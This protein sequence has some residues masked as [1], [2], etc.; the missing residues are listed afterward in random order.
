MGEHL[1]EVGQMFIF[2]LAGNQNFIQVGIAAGEATMNLW[3]AWAAFL[4]QKG[5]R[6]NWNNP[7]GVTTAVLGMV[8]LPTRR[9]VLQVGN[10]VL[11]QNGDVV[12]DSIVS[13]GLPARRD[14]PRDHVQRRDPAARRWANDA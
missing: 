12:Q 1:A 10:R 11:V 2:V 8:P 3:K 7:K 9:K 14:L 6:V 13:T 4:K 5:I